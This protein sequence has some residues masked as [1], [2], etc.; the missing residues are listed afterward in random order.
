MKQ[1]I[2]S[3]SAIICI[4]L[5]LPQQSMAQATLGDSYT[6]TGNLNLNL[7]LTPSSPQAF[8]FQKYGKVPINYATGVP[9]ISI[10]L[11]EIALKNF[12]WPVSLSYHAGGNRVEEIA[13]NAGLGWVL[14]AGGYLTSNFGWHTATDEPQRLLNLDGVAGPSVY[15]SECH[16]YNQQDIDLADEMAKRPNVPPVF[17]ITSPVLNTKFFLDAQTD[18]GYALPSASGL[19]ISRDGGNNTP[20]LYTIT[21]EDGNTYTFK[22]GGKSYK[23][24]QCG[25][26][27]NLT[28]N[29]TFV[30]DNITIYSG[31]TIQFYYEAINGIGYMMPKTYNRR[32]RENNFYPANGNI[33]TNIPALERDSC[34]SLMYADEYVLTGIEASNGVRIRFNI[35]TRNDMPYGKRVSSVQVFRNDYSTGNLIKTIEMAQGYFGSGGSTPDDL[36][37]KLESVTVKDKNN[38][39]AETYSFKY[40]STQLPG[41]LSINT[42]AAGFYRMGITDP[43]HFE[44]RD[45]NLA[46]TKACVLE[47]MTYPTGGHTK[48]TYGL[49]PWGGLRIDEIA[50]YDVDDKQYHF[51][52]FEYPQLSTAMPSNMDAELVW[53]VSQTENGGP[54]GD[55]GGG[56][57]PISCS[58]QRYQS[59]PVTPAYAVLN[60]DVNYYPMVTELYGNTMPSGKTEYYY[61]ADVETNRGDMPNLGPILAAKKVYAQ[62][63]SSF[64]LLQE[65]RVKYTTPPAAP[66][67]PF[68][69]SGNHPL[70]HK[71]W[72]KNIKKNRDELHATVGAGQVHFPKLFFQADMVI[73]SVPLQK[74]EEVNIV[75]SNGNVLETKLQYKYDDVNNFSPTEV[76]ITDSKNGELI[77]K[78][79]YPTNTGYSGAAL[80]AAEIQALNKLKNDNIKSRPYFTETYS[81]VQ[82]LAKKKMTYTELNNKAA[83]NKLTEWAACDAL[84]KSSECLQFDARLNCTESKTDDGRYTAAIFSPLSELYCQAVNAPLSDIAATSFESYGETGGFDFSGFVF[85]IPDTTAPT[86]KAV[87]NTG[88]G[89]SKTGLTPGKTF[90][91]SYWSKSGVLSVNGSSAVSG[92]SVNGWTYYEH[93]VTNPAT[94]TITITGGT[95]IDELRLYPSDALMTTYTY[96]PL[97]GLSTQC[98]ATNKINYYQ[99]DDLK[100]LKLIKDQDGNTV[101][102]FEYKYKTTGE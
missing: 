67:E 43:T 101:K 30:L 70:I 102:A 15:G 17:N 90:I 31:E 23:G 63:G 47:K 84:P 82:C 74:K 1:S 40:N 62:N 83:G 28:K 44:N 34:E 81:G 7:A 94:G 26:D 8:Q 77:T 42:D 78:L 4:V 56:A 36:R 61:G 97:T 45:Y 80:T 12:R 58:K 85:S 66:N 10:P 29:E 89:I 33:C 79:Y 87:G 65:D 37:L 59:G 55:Q 35:D 27:I 13:S 14:M 18:K 20:F 3:I 73:A 91:V 50:D 71:L 5:L 75:Y 93:K 92:R 64:T 21:D 19:R 16:Y 41:R 76:K 46:T 39:A 6:S 52:R 95:T 54:I 96:E 88:T 100:R 69:S 53:M 68:Y 49:N 9:N 32:V 60:Q 48:F 99:Y 86:G 98:D 22:Y 72:Y 51:R 2:T 38:V 57:W 25:G 11:Y 24:S